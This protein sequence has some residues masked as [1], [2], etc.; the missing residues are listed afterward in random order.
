MKHRFVTLRSRYIKQ[1]RLI[2]S[3]GLQRRLDLL[4]AV[5]YS[6]RSRPDL[7]DAPI[8]VL[9]ILTTSTAPATQNGASKMRTVL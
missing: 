3:D 8:P 4:Y 9:L 7:L 2:S 5:P 6:L 1:I